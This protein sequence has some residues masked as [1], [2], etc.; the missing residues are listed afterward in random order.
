MTQ[1]NDPKSSDEKPISDLEA[2]E[3]RRIILARRAKYVAYALMAAGAATNACGGDVE[4][5]QNTGGTGSTLTGGSSSTT[6]MHACLSIAAGGTSAI[7]TT[8]GSEGGAAMETTNTGGTRATTVTPCLKIAAGGSSGG[9]TPCLDIALPTGGKSSSSSALNTGA[10]GPC[11]SIAPIG[12][13]RATTTNQ[14][15]TVQGDGGASSSTLGPCLS[16]PR[17]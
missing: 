4:G 9:M 15:T 10:L 7:A 3:A 14:T 16:P 1:S 2:I 13:T 17:I 8:P 11:L 5:N 12:G 6:G